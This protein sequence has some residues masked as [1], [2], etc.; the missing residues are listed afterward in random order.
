MNYILSID[1]STQSTKAVLFDQEGSIIKRVDKRHK[2]I[3]NESGFIS[4]NPVEIYKNALQAVQ[5]V[6]DSCHVSHHDI[7]AVGISNQRETTVIWD[8]EGTP[9]ADAVV[10]QCSRASEIAKRYEEYNDEIYHITGLVLSPYF[11]ASKMRWLIEYV[12]PQRNYHFGTMDTWLIYCLTNGESFKTD[13]SNASRTQLFDI[14]NGCWSEA[15]CD[16]F[17]ID[18]KTLP[19]VCDSDAC[20][21]YTDFEGFLKHPIPICAVMGD[22]HAALFGQGCHK[23]GQVKTTLGTG[24]SIM[25]NIGQDYKQSRNGLTTSLAWRIQGATEYVLEGNINYAGAVISW[26]Q[27]DLNIIK[28]M[29]EII[30]AI[31]NSNR[32][33]ETVLVPAFSGLSAPYWKEDVRAMFYGMSRTTKRNELIKAAVESIAYQITDVLNAMASDSHL[34]LDEVKTDG[35]PSRNTYLMQYLSD[36]ARTS[37]LVSIQEELSAIGAAYLAGITAG[38]YRKEEIFA[39]RVYHTY[40]QRMEPAVWKKNMNRWYEAIHT[41]LGK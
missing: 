1:Q 8:D 21:G 26:L 5:E 38:I 24:S 39:H 34:S 17:Q 20:F 12:K 11:P 16:L 37:V 27:N 14:H 29:N 23:K 6:V 2:Q 33:D 22:S 7:K 3:I 25:M 9:L 28:D 15:L 19:Q 31:E 4:H 35:G 10:W 30:P 36:M 13:A 41:L 40:H 18:K 32:D